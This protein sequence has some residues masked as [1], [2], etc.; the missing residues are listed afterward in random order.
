MIG[1]LPSL[2]E[3]LTHWEETE[4]CFESQCTALIGWGEEGML[5]MF[6]LEISFWLVTL[7]FILFRLRKNKKR[8]K[9]LTK[10]LNA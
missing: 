5:A 9:A 1:D 2:W 8:N 3:G 6:A 4:I 10:S 7:T